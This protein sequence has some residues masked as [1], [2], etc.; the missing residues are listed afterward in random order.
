METKVKYKNFIIS[1]ILFSA[2][3]CAEL[4]RSSTAILETNISVSSYS[5]KPDIKIIVSKE[6]DGFRDELVEYIDDMKFFR[7]YSCIYSSDDNDDKMIDKQYKIKLFLYSENIDQSSFDKFVD[8]I[9]IVASATTLG[10][11]PMP[12]PKYYVIHGW[13]YDNENKILY[14]NSV[15]GSSYFF[16][17]ASTE[18]GMVWTPHGP[19]SSMVLSMAKKLLMQII[20]ESHLKDAYQP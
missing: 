7:S 12:F 16:A 11:I 20:S 10:L 15:E 8:S 1:I 19:P 17:S 14:T 5:K 6:Y 4:P 18:G 13:L 9:K 3:G 2:F